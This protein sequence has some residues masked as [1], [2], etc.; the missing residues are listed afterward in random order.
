[1]VWIS[2][3]FPKFLLEKL[4]KRSENKDGID[5]PDD[6]INMSYL[7]LLRFYGIMNNRIVILTCH[8][9]TFLSFSVLYSSKFYQSILL[10]APGHHCCFL[11]F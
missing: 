1:M 4:Y 5:M 7:F 11:V 6:W 8:S 3:L 9:D 2:F 10:G